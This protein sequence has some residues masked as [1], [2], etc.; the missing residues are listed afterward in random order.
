MLSQIVIDLPPTMYHVQHTPAEEVHRQLVAILAIC[1]AVLVFDL[2][3]NALALHKTL[4]GNL[5][6]NTLT[7]PKTLHKTLYKTLH[8]TLLGLF[9]PIWAAA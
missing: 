9:P 5:A 6:Q 1:A 8:K 2:V 7:L 4:L 3:Q